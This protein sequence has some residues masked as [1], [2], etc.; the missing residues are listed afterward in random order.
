MRDLLPLSRPHLAIGCLLSFL[1]CSGT[2]GGADAAEEAWPAPA[3]IL[4]PSCQP[5]DHGRSDASLAGPANCTRAYLKTDVSR[6]KAESL[7]FSVARPTRLVERAVETD[8]MWTPRNGIGNGSAAQG[9]ERMTRVRIHLAVD[10]YTLYKLDPKACD[11]KQC[12]VQVDGKPQLVDAAQCTPF[13]VV[14]VSGTLA[15]KDG[16]VAAEFAHQPAMN[17]FGDGDSKPDETEI[18]IQ[19]NLHDVHGGLMIDPKVPDPRVGDLRL[20]LLYKP[21]DELESGTVTILVIQ[22]GLPDGPVPDESFYQPLD[23]YLAL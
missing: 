2:G 7:G 6:S 20:D 21:S 9:Y 17:A 4:C 5:G 18:F 11:S 3:D 13:M 22:D 23:G 12:T 15:T 10:S 14:N 16:A 1:A 8:M 19:A